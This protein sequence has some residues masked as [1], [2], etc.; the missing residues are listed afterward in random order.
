MRDSDA[1]KSGL[2]LQSVDV[3]EFADTNRLATFVANAVVDA[4]FDFDPNL[5]VGQFS[6]VDFVEA[7]LCQL[8]DVD[9]FVSFDSVYV[10]AIPD[11]NVV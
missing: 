8:F 1:A 2:H 10:L 3:R 6:S 9:P 4:I 5:D 11:V 7:V